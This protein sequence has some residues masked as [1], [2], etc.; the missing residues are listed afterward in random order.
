[1]ATKHCEAA[2]RAIQT[3]IDELEHARDMLADN[4]VAVNQKGTFHEQYGIFKGA[5][6]QTI[7]ML[8]HL[9][10]ATKAVTA[11][12]KN[13]VRQLSSEEKTTSHG[14]TRRQEDEVNNSSLQERESALSTSLHN[15]SDILVG[16][17]DDEPGTADG[18]AGAG[19]TT[20]DTK[21]GV[22]VK[23]TPDP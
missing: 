14:G 7:L 1:M 11:E 18:G 15:C 21:T 12:C 23:P 9:T 13:T 3:A 10:F 20:N 4:F 17:D 2:T 8:E 5:V 6:S 19:A 22:A 16:M